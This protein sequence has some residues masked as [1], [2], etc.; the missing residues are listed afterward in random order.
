MLE[1][2]FGLGNWRGLNAC[3]LAPTLPSFKAFGMG[4]AGRVDRVTTGQDPALN[5]PASVRQALA[6]QARWQRQVVQ[7]ELAIAGQAFE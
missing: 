2:A 4:A 5:L 1:L 7:L 6:A 3:A